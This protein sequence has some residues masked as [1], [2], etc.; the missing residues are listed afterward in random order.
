MLKPNQVS[1]DTNYTSDEVLFCYRGCIV[2]LIMAGFIEIDLR[3]VR[4]CSKMCL[5]LFSVSIA[6]LEGLY[7]GNIIGISQAAV[8]LNSS[9]WHILYV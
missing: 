8:I 7:K 1:N 2:V 6:M 3:D 4:I 5:S 9:T